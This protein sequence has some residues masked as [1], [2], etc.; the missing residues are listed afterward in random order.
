[1]DLQPEQI[2]SLSLRTRPATQGVSR[3]YA[4]AVAGSVAASAALAAACAPAGQSS[5]GDAA[6]APQKR[7]VNLRYTTFWNQQRLD[8]IA[9][10]IQQFEQ[11][12]GH[13][14]SMEPVTNYAEKLEFEG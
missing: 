9:P 5:G 13:R 6:G 3:R 2:R 4:V 1:M 10:A 12:T 7:S 8:V 11:E 14:V